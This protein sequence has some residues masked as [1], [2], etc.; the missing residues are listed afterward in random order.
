MIYIVETTETF[1]R[2][3]RRKHRDKIEWLKKIKEKLENF[4]E[5]GKPLK[6]RLH[7]IWQIRI[8]SFRVWYEVNHAEKK[9]IIRAILHKDDAVEKY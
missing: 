5:Y 4:P 8:E 7:G 1:E 3:F 2:E 9:V 6:G